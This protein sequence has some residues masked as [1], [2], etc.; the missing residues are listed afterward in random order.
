MDAVHRIHGFAK[1]GN[2]DMYVT[3]GVV[4]SEAM[5]PADAYA[6][7]VWWVALSA[8][9]LVV[10]AAGLILWEVINLRTNQRRR[11][12]YDRAQS[13]LI[14]AQTELAMV[15]VRAAIAAGRVATLLRISADGLALL[16]SELRLVGWNQ[17]FA[18]DCGVPPDTL[19]EDLPIDELIRY[20][21]RA[22]LIGSPHGNDEEAME[23]EIAQRV[24]I[25]RTEPADA[26]LPQLRSDGRQAALR[27]SVVPENGGLVLLL[28]E[29]ESEI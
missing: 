4:Q 3:V 14:S 10:A 21:A 26:V 9:V 28:S 11:R 25:L 7:G 22:G 15:R 6:S 27:V 17:R 20:Q 12:R 29:S 2:R 18:A 5:A 1:V 8:S 24:A 16:D 19:Q 13:D 23:T